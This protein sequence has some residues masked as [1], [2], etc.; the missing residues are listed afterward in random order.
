MLN[1]IKILCLISLGIHG[2]TAAHLTP[3]QRVGGSNPSGFSVFSL[4]NNKKLKKM[5]N[6]QAQILIL[7][8][9]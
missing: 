2:A 6:Y 5:I 8:S 9:I 3:D 4:R 7:L 1:I